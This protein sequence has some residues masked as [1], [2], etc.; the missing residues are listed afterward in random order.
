MDARV[1]LIRWRAPHP[2]GHDL[3]VPLRI[4]TDPATILELVGRALAADPV[5]NT[6]FSSI[7]AGVRSSDGDGW[8]AHPAQHP[9]VLAARSRP[10]TPVA[11]T[12]GWTDLGQLADC[13]PSPAGLGG[14]VDAVETLA[15]ELA[16]RG[17]HPSARM[18]ER[19]FRCDEL[20]DPRGVAGRSRLAVDRDVEFL[21]GWYRDFVTEAFA[22]PGPS[23]DDPAT[24]IRHSMSLGARP[25]LWLDA[26]GTPAAMAVRH[27]IVAGVSRIG[28]VYTPPALRG[29]GYGSAVTAA[30]TRD[31]LDAGG[32]PVLYTDVANPT[33]NAIYQ[34]LGFRAVGDRLSIAYR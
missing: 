21:A 28:P 7:D 34:Q 33:S 30:A 12:P 15:N 32:T 24:M 10:T 5:V 8:C 29:R 13:M 1:P 6:V 3:P 26:A 18:A 25:W 9:D 23:T 22:R 31:I 2:T 20:C 27:R 17:L 4:T 11:L 14:P 19:L 16:A